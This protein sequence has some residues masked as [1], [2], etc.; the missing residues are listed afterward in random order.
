MI[1]VGIDVS[2]GKSTVCIMK[3]YGEVLLGPEEYRHTESDLGVLTDIIRGFNEETRVVMEATGVYHLPVAISLLNKDIFV[4]V[5]NPYLMRQ[6]AR[7][8]IRKVKTDRKDSVTIAQYGLEKWYS[9][10]KYHVTEDV[11]SELKALNRQYTF[12]M[13]L[14]VGALQNLNHLLDYTMPGVRGQFKSRNSSGGKDK[15]SDFSLRFWHYDNIRKMSERK[16]VETYNRWAEKKGYRK[17]NEKAITI[18]QMARNG[19]PALPASPSTKMLIVQAVKV[20]NG[21]DETLNTILARMKEI[22]KGL[23]EYSVAMDMDG[24]GETLAV[25]LVAETG[26]LR[27]FENGKALVAYAGVDPPPFESGSFIGTNRKIT[28]RGSAALRKTAYEVIRSIMSHK[29]PLNSIYNFIIKKRLEGKPV[30]VSNI[31]GVNKFLR[32]YYARVMETY[33]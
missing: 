19:I 7:Q 33:I 28:K 3:D 14:H 27:R 22:A 15:L 17:S 8:G 29:P 12:Y 9:L 2:K 31:A 5:I 10:K 21:V 18:H 1:S 20:L 30:K 4:S 26:D 11:Y 13:K 6:Y 25:R 16:F 32:I 24:V 23:P